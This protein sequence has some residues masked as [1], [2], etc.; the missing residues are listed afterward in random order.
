MKNT[1]EAKRYILKSFEESLINMDEEKA[2]TKSNQLEKH[3]VKKQWRCGSIDHSQVTTRDF[4]VGVTY[5]N[6]DVFPQRWDYLNL[7]QIRQ[8]K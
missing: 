8:D 1:C 6:N 3:M 2:L 4:I 5:R 7:R